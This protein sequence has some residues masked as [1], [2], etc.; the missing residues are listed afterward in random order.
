MRRAWTT[1]ASAEP[2]PPWLNFSCCFTGRQT[3]HNHWS[4]QLPFKLK[5]VSKK[6][7]TFGTPKLVLGDEMQGR[8]VGLLPVKDGGQ[9]A[10]PGLH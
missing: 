2:S 10:A 8:F 5:G 6:R 3:R 7:R 1:D 4:A 9:G